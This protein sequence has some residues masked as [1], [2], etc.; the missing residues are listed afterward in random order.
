MAEYSSS[1]TA[2]KVAEFNRYDLNRDGFVTPAEAL[3]GER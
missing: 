2:A 3:A 1:W